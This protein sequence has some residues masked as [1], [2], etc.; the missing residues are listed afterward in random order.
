MDPSK[1][2]QTP[3]ATEIDQGTPSR[4]V[5]RGAGDEA[6]ART[7]AGFSSEAVGSS[8]P[9]LTSSPPSAG[10][11]IRPARRGDAG[12][13]ISLL[14]E[15]GLA[16]DTQTVAWIISHPEMELLVAADGLD[17]AI[18]FVSLT[19]RPALKMGGRSATIDELL[20]SKDWR[21]RGVGRELLR[22]AVER[23]RVLK[24]KRV[25]LQSFGPPDPGL[26]AFLDACGF[27]RA[28]VGIFR[29]R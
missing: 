10:F 16:S 29:L 18:G 14:A 9:V 2:P 25:E 24:V 6:Q 15:V 8:R 7:P 23:A 3:G 19:H 27:E 13:I 28:E 21:R 22:K 26:G 11:R 1:A 17:R 20:V 4:L 12:L 5:E